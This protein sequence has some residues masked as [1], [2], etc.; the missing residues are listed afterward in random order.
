MN[1][2]SI[3][4]YTRIICAL[5]LISTA[6]L[7]AGPT[8]AI[9]Q[10]TS[11]PS[12]DKV[13]TGAV[14]ALEQ[15]GYIHGKTA[16]ILFENAQGNMSTA[17]QIAQKF[18][19]KNPDVIIA[20]ATPS[21]QTAMKATKQLKTPIIFGSISDPLGTGL[22]NNLEHP[23]GMV[24]G[25][26]NVSPLNKQLAL[27]KQVLPKAKTIGIVLN[28]GEAHSI[29][30]LEETTQVAKSLSLKVIPAAANTSGDVQ[31]AT[32]NLMG[33]VDA[34]F[35]LQDNTI[36]SALPALLKVTH[37]A[38]IPVFASYIEAV[39]QGA[40]MG[41]A[42][43]EYAIGLQTGQMAVRVLH[44]ESIGDM[45]VEDPEKIE[46]IINH[47]VADNLGITVPEGLVNKK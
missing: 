29:Q 10:I 38:K 36:A 25:T 39:E 46:L 32:R 23:G 18:A 20:I 2:I 9:T 28:Y 19:S 15:A 27:I 7:L 30:L 3:L 47:K 43:D 6:P 42:F 5:L 24:S 16:T 35:L 26:R 17:A 33:K 45:P 44:G 31:M 13:Q 37:K 12:L 8:I 4:K 40:L 34:I 41:L 22:V 21:V 14:T 1:L 11:H